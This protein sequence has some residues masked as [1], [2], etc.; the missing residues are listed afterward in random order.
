VDTTGAWRGGRF[1]TARPAGTP[2]RFMAIGDTNPALG[3]TA[4]ILTNVLP[5]KPDFVVHMGD[6]Q[7]YSSIIE[8]Q[9]FWFRKMQPM[10]SE[11]GGFFPAIGNHEFELKSATFDEWADYSHRF[12]YDPSAQLDGQPQY[13]SFD[14]GGVTFA[15]IDTEIPWGAGSDQAVWLEATLA[16]AKAR[17]GHRFAVVY[18]HR[19]LYTLGDT[20][21]ELSQRHDL[22]PI[23]EAQG[24]RLV[25]QG[26]MHG[27]ERF[28]VPAAG[29][30]DIPVITTAGG[31][32]TI[33]DLNQ[34]VGKYPADAPL[35]TSYAAKPHAVDFQVGA[36][37]LHGDVIDDGGVLLDSFDI[38]V[39]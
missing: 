38:D 2:F 23:F 3:R 34:N 30:Y 14:W 39:P 15:A 29:G 10:L 6:I 22:W 32:A 13:Y 1:C 33:G 16:A 37:S 28:M 4:G 27:Y 9:V 35:R 19:C 26:H 24:V 8:T 11:G 12:W 25:L 17:P 31:G 18:M 20:D 5:R 7:Y 21:A 36:G